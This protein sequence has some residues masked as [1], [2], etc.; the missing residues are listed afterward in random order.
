[1]NG[2]TGTIVHVFKDTGRFGVDLQC[3]HGSKSIKGSNLMLT[4]DGEDAQDS[5]GGA[6]LGAIARVRLLKFSRS[7]PALRQALLDASELKACRESLKSQ[8]LAVELP[9]GAKMFVRPEHYA[10]ALEAIRIQG[11]TLYP[12]HVVEDIDIESVVLAVVQ[13]LRG[14]NFAYPKRKQD[15]PLGFAATA[16]ESGIQVEVARS[17]L[18]IRL[19]SVMCS[20]S[21]SAAP[22]TSSTTDA[23]PRKGPN[24]RRGKTRGKK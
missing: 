7:L 12:D 9:S 23:Q 6:N 5:T 11:L 22:R 3:S 2:C 8:G 15:I 14:R 19:S 10:P 17:F 16:L 18:H 20:S 24:P 4:R 21:D 1:V 13:D